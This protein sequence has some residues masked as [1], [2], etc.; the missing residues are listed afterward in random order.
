MLCERRCCKPSQQQTQKPGQGRQ[1][2]RQQGGDRTLIYPALKPVSGGKYK[3]LFGIT[4]GMIAS[5]NSSI[6][7]FD[8]SLMRILIPEQRC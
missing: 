5:I 2:G 3:M 1:Q 4:V 8:Y 6:T 7:D